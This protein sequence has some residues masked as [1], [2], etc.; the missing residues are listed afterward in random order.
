[1]NEP[2]Q[3]TKLIIIYFL[4]TTSAYERLQ[5][6]KTKS[7]SKENGPASTFVALQGPQA[8]QLSPFLSGN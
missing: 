4:Q 1:M 8:Q 2:R 7:K 3:A 6:S 5:N